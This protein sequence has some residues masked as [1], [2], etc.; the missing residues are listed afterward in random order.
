MAARAIS[1]ACSADWIAAPEYI[2]RPSSLTSHSHTSSPLRSRWGRTSYVELGLLA[3]GHERTDPA[4]PRNHFAWC[5][6]PDFR[7]KRAALRVSRPGVQTLRPLAKRELLRIPCLSPN[8]WS[9]NLLVRVRP[10]R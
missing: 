6:V 10:R 9:S 7:F 2:K 4:S 1:F 8:L 5:E 3:L